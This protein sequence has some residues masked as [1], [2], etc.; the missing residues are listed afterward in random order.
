M[1]CLATTKSP[2]T[3]RGHLQSRL[4]TAVHSYVFAHFLLRIYARNTGLIAY[5]CILTVWASAEFEKVM[6]LVCVV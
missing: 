4:G 6:V 1:S 2:N 5:V 3:V